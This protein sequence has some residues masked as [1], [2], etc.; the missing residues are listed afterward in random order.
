MFS[1][2]IQRFV[3]AGSC[4]RSMDYWTIQINRRKPQS[5]NGWIRWRGVKLWLSRLA[6]W[7][8]QQQQLEQKHA[9]CEWWATHHLHRWLEIGRRRPHQSSSLCFSKENDWQVLQPRTTTTP[10]YAFTKNF[11][12]VHDLSVQLDSHSQSMGGVV[13][14]VVYSY[15][16]SPNRIIAMGGF[17]N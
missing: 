12:M 14:V 16:D 17:S 7:A 9:G 6:E 10:L 11:P 4:L 3:C 1:R 5:R 8:E 2:S 15:M 13:V